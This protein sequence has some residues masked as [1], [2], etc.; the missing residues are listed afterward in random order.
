MTTASGF[1]GRFRRE[2]RYTVWGWEEMIRMGSVR[3]TFE[4]DQICDT[5]V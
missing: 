4:K 3:R 2:E 5:L 1:K